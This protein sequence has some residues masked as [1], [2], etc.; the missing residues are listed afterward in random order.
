MDWTLNGGTFCPALRQ[1]IPRPDSSSQQ[2][3]DFLGFPTAKRCHHVGITSRR[4]K[5]EEKWVLLS[6]SSGSERHSS[7]FIQ[8]TPTEEHMATSQT[9][10]Q[11]GRGYRAMPIQGIMAT[12]PQHHALPSS[13]PPFSAG[14]SNDRARGPG[15]AACHAAHAA[16]A[17][18]E[19]A[20]LWLDE[21]TLLLHLLHPHCPTTISASCQPRLRPRKSC[22]HLDTASE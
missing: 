17:W 7:L 21:S 3:R 16:L 22:S 12:Q 9:L 19:R 14:S 13:R 5:E 20:D 11:A 18:G 1:T 8:R 6:R 10:R 2:R 15:P 4:R